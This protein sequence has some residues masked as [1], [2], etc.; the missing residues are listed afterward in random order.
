M[1]QED[2]IY[3]KLELNKDKNQ[4]LS[5]TT[6]FNPN[7]PNFYKEGDSYIWKPTLK[8]KNFVMEAFNLLIQNNDIHNN[9]KKIYKFSDKLSY[10]QIFPSDENNPNI[11]SNELRDEDLKKCENDSL[12]DE[13]CNTLKNNKTM[14]LSNDDMIKESIDKNKIEKYKLSK[15]DRDRKIEKILRENKK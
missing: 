7:S 5:I 1:N 12:I 3:I 13:D 4:N 10:N 6:Y 15:N 8:E 2:E 11:K 9:D 14:N